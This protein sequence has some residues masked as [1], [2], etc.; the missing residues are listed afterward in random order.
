MSIYKLNSVCVFCGAS[1]GSDAQYFHAAQEV[2][3]HFAKENISL[4]YGGGGIGLMGVLA[5]TAI[6]NGG[7]AIG[8]IPKFL[9]EREVAQQG[10]TE[11]ISVNSMHERKLKMAQLSDAFILLPGGFGSLEEFFEAVTWTQLGLQEKPVGILNVAGYF[12][13]LLN[14]LDNAVGCGFVFH[15]HREM[16]S[17]SDNITDLLVSLSKTKLPHSRLKLRDKGKIL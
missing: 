2:G 16:I 11:A 17:A 12:D 5:T 6:E 4:V 9:K 3:R 8:V 14:F 1:Q 13:S 15:E 10:L 7:K